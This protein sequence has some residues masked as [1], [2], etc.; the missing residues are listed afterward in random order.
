[1]PLAFAYVKR[2]KALRGTQWL[3]GGI[4]AVVLTL[5]V[6]WVLFVPVVDWLA[7]RR[8]SDGIAARDGTG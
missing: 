6:V 3:A 4:A 2:W 7:H 5:V 8:H 1:M